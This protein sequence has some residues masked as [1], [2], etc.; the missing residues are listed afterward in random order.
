MSRL[1]GLAFNTPTLGGWLSSYLSFFAALNG[2]LA[3]VSVARLRRT[4][5]PGDFVLVAFFAGISLLPIGAGWPF[6][7]MFLLAMCLRFASRIGTEKLYREHIRCKS[8][9]PSAGLE[10]A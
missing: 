7:E 9:A 4:R 6:P 1:S 5:H 3:Q 10:G 2:W 8:I